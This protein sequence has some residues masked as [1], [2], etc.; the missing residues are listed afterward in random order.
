MSWSV[1]ERPI[2]I[3]SHTRQQYPVTVKARHTG[4][5]VSIIDTQSYPEPGTWPSRLGQVVTQE[6]FHNKLPCYVE[7]PSQ[8]VSTCPNRPDLALWRSSLSSGVCTAWAGGEVTVLRGGL[9][10]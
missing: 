9:T 7:V 8:S 1:T 5:V 10:M 3:G 4:I 6:Y 2:A